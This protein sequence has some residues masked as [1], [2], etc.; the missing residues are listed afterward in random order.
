MELRPVPK[1]QGYDGPV[2]VPVGHLRTNNFP[3]RLVRPLSKHPPADLI[4][5]KTWALEMAE[6]RRSLNHAKQAE[7]AQTGH[8]GS[9]ED[10][11]RGTLVGIKILK[12][13]PL[14]NGQTRIFYRRKEMMTHS[15]P[16]SHYKNFVIT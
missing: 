14:D 12:T 11:V 6:K 9:I 3:G 16:F 10:P 5:M 8:D 2:R 1:G 13:I 4:R 15:R 7:L